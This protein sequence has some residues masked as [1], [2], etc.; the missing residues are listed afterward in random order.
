VV[1]VE[2]L[3][4]ESGL[5]LRFK[6]KMAKI[7]VQCL[8]K[9]FA[10]KARTYSHRRQ[11]FWPELAE[12]FCLGLAMP[13]QQPFHQPPPPPPQH[14]TTPSGNEEQMQNDDLSSCLVIVRMWQIVNVLASIKLKLNLIAF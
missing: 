3:Y 1:G 2:L 6:F 4:L 10:A 7:K 5:K 13:R 12:K 8:Q 9:F 14:T 11:L